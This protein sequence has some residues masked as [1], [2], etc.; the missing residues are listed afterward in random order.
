MDYLTTADTIIV[1]K[2]SLSTLAL[3]LLSN[4]KLHIETTKNLIILKKRV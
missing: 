3:L 2:V 1:T 4:V